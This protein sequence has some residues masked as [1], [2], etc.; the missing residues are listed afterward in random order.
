MHFLNRRQNVLRKGST[1]F[2]QGVSAGG[3]F[4]INLEESASMSGLVRWTM[5]DTAA[6]S[7]SAMQQCGSEISIEMRTSRS[8]GQDIRLLQDIVGEVEETSIDEVDGDEH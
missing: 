2:M 1:S 7:V 8:G 6:A 5:G 4:T 3:N